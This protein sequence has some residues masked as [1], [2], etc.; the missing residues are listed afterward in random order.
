MSASIKWLIA[1][2]YEEAEVPDNLRQLF[3]RTE[4]VALLT[5]CSLHLNLFHCLGSARA[6]TA[7]HRWSNKWV[8]LLSR[9]SQN[10]ARPLPSDGITSKRVSTNPITPFSAEHWQTPPGIL[11]TRHRSEG[12]RWLSRHGIQSNLDCAA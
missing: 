6:V 7:C 8:I 4:E 5:A 3:H 1:R 11:F 9:I 2:I 10:H 12:G